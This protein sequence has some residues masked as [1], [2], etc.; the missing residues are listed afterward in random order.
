MHKAPEDVPSRFRA[1]APALYAEF[2]RHDAE[3]C[4]LDRRLM[5]QLRADEKKF[6][7]LRDELARAEAKHAKIVVPLMRAVVTAEAKENAAAALA[8][9]QAVNRRLRK[10]RAPTTAALALQKAFDAAVHK[11]DAL[12]DRIYKTIAKK[13]AKS[14]SDVKAKLEQVM[15]EA[16]RADLD[17][18]LFWLIEGAIADLKRMAAH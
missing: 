3:A 9:V 17:I 10:L 15:L 7:P 5:A 4:A 13:P 1:I 6:A 2:E 8:E 11:R 12:Q 14:L 18:R 16:Q